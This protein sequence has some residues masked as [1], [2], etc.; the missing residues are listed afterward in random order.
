MKTAASVSLGLAPLAVAAVALLQTAPTPPRPLTDLAPAGPALV[1]QAKDFSALVRD[2]NNSAEKALWLKSDNY[3]VFERSDLF[4]RMGEERGKFAAAAAFAPDMS[5]LDWLA[6]GESLLALY[7]IRNFEF[8]YITRH[9]P[10]RAMEGLLWKSRG[11]KSRSSAG[12]PFVVRIDPATRR[13]VA[14]AVAGDLLLAASR[15]DLIAGAL[16]LIAGNPGVTVKNE[17]WFD[18]SVHTAGQ[19]GDLRLVMNLEKIVRAHPFRSHWIQGNNSELRQYTAGVSD[20][21]RTPAEFREERVLLRDPQTPAAAVNGAAAGE[22]LRLAPADAGIYRAWANPPVDAA[23]D[24]L[25]HKILAPQPVARANRLIAPMVSLDEGAAASEAD[26]ET[27]IDEAPLENASGRFVAEA[28]RKL[29]EGN[30]LQA[31]LEVS[32]SQAMPDGVFAGFSSAVALVGQTDWNPGAARSALAD[33]VRSLWTTSGVGA[34]WIVR[35]TGARAHDELDGLNRISVFTQ[36]RLLVV[37]TDPKALESVV[38]GLGRPPAAA[39]A[40][41]AGFNHASER[42]NFDRMM[43]LLD[44]SSQQSANDTRQP[45]FFSEN[46]G[47][48]S[49]T[50]ARIQSESIVVRDSGPSV[51]QTMIYRLGK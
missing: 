28:V 17:P 13:I 37:A 11:Y 30:P 47:S 34:N 42:A 35:G 49:R 41:A 15:E 21:F 25:E 12:L 3:A 18:R 6:G 46:I 2:W 1:L 40:Y 51:R 44:Q 45:Y 7:D 10:A 24:L 14:F 38:D 19:A 5:T 50:L 22:L 26:L 8:L 20:L 4:W 32:S 23:L 16:S 27:R 39:A 43:G 33:A 31:M 9:A 36:G 29:L 48:L